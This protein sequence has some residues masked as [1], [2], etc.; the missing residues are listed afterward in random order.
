MGE[1]ISFP[2]LHVRKFV[3]PNP[4]EDCLQPLAG[5]PAIEVM[6]NVFKVNFD[7]LGIAYG[8][9]AAD[10]VEFYTDPRWEGKILVDVDNMPNRP[11]VRGM[12]MVQPED[13]ELVKVSDEP[14][15]HFLHNE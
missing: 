1:V 6:D 10:C 2:D 14:L 4:F 5:I 12:Y 13:Y 15:K 11:D 3:E 7:Y 9:E 8:V